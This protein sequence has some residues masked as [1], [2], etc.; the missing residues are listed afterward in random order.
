M[1]KQKME[2]PSEA[3][4]NNFRWLVL[5]LLFLN[6]FF[7]ML[8][9][10]SIPPLFKEIGEEIPLTKA[11]MGIIMGMITVPSLFFSLIGGGISDKV[12]SRWAFGVCVLIV[13]IAGTFRAIAG[14]VYGLAV[15]MFLMGIGLSTLGPNFS[16]ALVMWFPPRELAM[17]NGIC[18]VSMPLA[19]T[20]GMGTAAGVFS[21]GLGGWR[22]VM[23]AL[24]I[25]TFV[26]GLLWMTLFR[27]GKLHEANGEKKQS[28]IDNFKKVFKVKDI[29]WAS[30][31]YSF[32]MIGVMSVFTLLPHS[33]S[34]RGL[35]RAMAGVLVAVMT[36]TNTVFKIVGGTLSDRTGKRKPFLFISSIVL[37]ICIFA[38]S[39]FTGLPLIIALIIAGAAMGTISPI[40]M[41]TL[42]ELKEIGPALAATTTGLIFMIGN[43]F[44]FI[45]P[46][47]S[48][49][50]MD[51]TGAQW[52]GFLFMGLAFVIAAF[53]ILP[54]RETGQKKKKEI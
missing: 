14:S 20:V 28:I 41:V 30:I 3:Q 34:E 24:G 5:V 52:P 43:V 10:Q 18:M 23:V 54:V 17:A 16:K 46:I 12:G 33:L 48:G 37:G 51:V 25:C 4:K 19:L 53:F 7:V 22:N 26:T 13:S 49:K 42:V 38:F 32:T 50:L 15:C 21:P 6:M 35:T 29:W 44:G 45:G 31:F 8:A 2:T 27:E 40:F 9:V 36:G 1:E 39:T 11:E 47:V